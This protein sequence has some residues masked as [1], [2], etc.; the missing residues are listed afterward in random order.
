MRANPNML[1]TSRA[2]DAVGIRLMGIIDR[3]IHWT[4]GVRGVIDRSRP[5]TIFRPAGTVKFRSAHYS[6]KLSPII[7]R[8]VTRY[9]VLRTNRKN[10]LRFFDVTSVVLT[11]FSKKKVR[12]RITSY[13]NTLYRTRILLRVKKNKRQRDCY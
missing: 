11:L 5:V 8:R 6:C 1:K 9:F 2:R 4:H 10:F 12:L 13:F 3:E 7:H